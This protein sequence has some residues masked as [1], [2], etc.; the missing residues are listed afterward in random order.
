M[1]DIHFPDESELPP[2]ANA[3]ADG[4]TGLINLDY[5]EDFRAGFACVVGRPNVGKSTLMN[6]MVGSKIAITSNTPETTRRVIRGVVHHEDWQLVLVDTPGLHKPRTLLGKRLNDM[7]RETL[8]AVDIVVFCIPADQDIGPGD[9]YI[10][11]E[12]AELKTPVICAVTK[13]DLVPR[14][15]VLDQL[16]AAHELG[17][18]A[19]FIP[20][21]GEKGTQVEDL[22]T[23]LAGYLP[24]SPPLYPDGELTDEPENVMIAEIIREAALAGMREELPHSVAVQVEEI[25]ERPARDDGTPGLLDVHVNVFVERDS[26]KAI[27][28]GKGGGN[29][30]KIGTKA[31]RGIEAMLGRHI[32][33]D[34]HVRTAKEWQRDPKMLNRLGF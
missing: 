1:S 26:Q 33:L 7:V 10:A 28:I 16:A 34:L 22:G 21:S 3:L 13:I 27:I 8:T 5:P 20:V 4:Y 14:E 23:L 18:F 32:Y 29:L 2:E 25:I 24:E 15:R 17:D 30:R 6:A 31:R 19:E 11:S 9:R 12:L